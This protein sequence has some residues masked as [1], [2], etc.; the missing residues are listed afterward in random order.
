MQHWRS[1]GYAVAHYPVEELGTIVVP[2]TRHTHD[3]GGVDDDGQVQFSVGN[4]TS[5][6]GCRIVSEQERLWKA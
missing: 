5:G 1:T 2:Y 4:R 3:T 6:A